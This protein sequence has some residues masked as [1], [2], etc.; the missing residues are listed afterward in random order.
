MKKDIERIK[1]AM[2]RVNDKRI[3]I[4]FK[5]IAKLHTIQSQKTVK[6]R[7]TCYQG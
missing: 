1:I 3:I 5:S 4:Q 7:A 2:K 6:F